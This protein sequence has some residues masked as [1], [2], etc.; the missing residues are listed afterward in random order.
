MTASEDGGGE[1]ECSTEK[2]VMDTKKI[3]YLLQNF[4]LG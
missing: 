1:A 4:E 2:K 3:K